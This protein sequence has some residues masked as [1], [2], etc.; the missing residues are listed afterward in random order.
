[1][2]VYTQ[3]KL[4]IKSW[5]TEVE[6]SAM[7]QAVN[8]SNLPF[9]FHHI[10]L[11]PDCH[12]GYGMPIGGVLATKDVIIPNAVGVDIGCGMIVVKTDVTKV[13]EDKLIKT[14]GRCRERIPV[15]FNKHKESQWWNTL[16]SVKLY[17]SAKADGGLFVVNSE[18][19]KAGYSI[20]TLGG[21]NHFIEIQRGDDG[22]VYLMIHSGS[23]NLGKT[24]ADHYNKLAV[25]LNEQWY[26][27]VSKEH[28]LAFL[29]A[30]SDEGRRYL[31]EM[32]FC[33]RY[34][35]L[36]RYIMMK[37]L[38]D[39]F[40]E[41][42]SAHFDDPINIH[43]NYV[44]LENHFGHNVYVHRKGAI[45]VQQ[46]TIGIIP[47]S[48]GTPSYIVEGLGNR[49]S[50]ESASHG[51]GRRMSR[52]AANESITESEATTAMQGI[53]Y[54]RFNGKYD[55]APQAYK[56]IIQVMADQYDLV[57]PLVKLSPLAVMKG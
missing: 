12:S 17:D 19:D 14:I 29:P 37:C 32:E 15:G 30:K 28:Q 41:C 44:A 6:E 8:L 35:Q 3:G 50:F 23:R 40:E 43:H 20:G 7:E 26:S 38:C 13:S 55:E 56:D 1:M 53:V 39:A 27:Q 18:L 9:A 42:T 45:K 36:N 48:M 10:A 16:D 22:Y 21:G 31:M 57:K 52:K 47:G 24:V 49:E 4:P 11:M 34:A 2:K 33:L 51:A 46:G 54:G 5:A 25:S